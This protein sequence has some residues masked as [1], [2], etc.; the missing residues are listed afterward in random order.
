M[1]FP[2]K[3]SQTEST[4]ILVS[5][6]NSAAG[7]TEQAWCLSLPWKTGRSIETSWW[8]LC[9]QSCSESKGW[10]CFPWHWR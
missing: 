8:A 6:F 4:L 7:A 9:R 5:F 1:T 10:F 2:R 3:N